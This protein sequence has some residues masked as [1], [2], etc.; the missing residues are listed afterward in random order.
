M[1]MA[2]RAEREKQAARKARREG[3]GDGDDHAG[4]AQPPAAGAGPRPASPNPGPA[5]AGGP[6]GAQRPQRE[7]Y[8]AQGEWDPSTARYGLTSPFMSEWK[9]PL[10]NIAADIPCYEPPYGRIAVIDLNT[11]KQLWSRAI[12][13]MDEIGPFGIKTGLPFQVGTPIYG[14]TITTRGGVIFQV[15]T[16]D[17]T[18]RALNIRNGE[19]LW[20][21]ELPGTSNG[22][23]ITYLSRKSGRQMVVVPV[24]NPGF[25]YP[26][27]SGAE[28]EGDQGGYVIAYALPQS[29]P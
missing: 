8:T 24:P 15:G 26:R 1:M 21:A 19:T 2:A 13:T 3:R 28:P 27:D 20:E 5:A 7:P 25:I 6:G 18:M 16:M 23:P 11:G 10:T 14:G 9:I 17:S 12:G 29:A 4:P 22:T